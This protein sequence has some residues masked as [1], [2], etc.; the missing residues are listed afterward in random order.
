MN[1]LDY[2]RVGI[3]QVATSLAD[4]NANLEKHRQ[5]IDQ[6][7]AQH[8]DLLLFPELSLTGYNLK[9]QTLDVALPTSHEIFDELAAIATNM[10]VCVGFVEE[11]APGEFYNAHAILKHGQM[12][13][14]HRKIN[15]PNYGP[16]EEGKWF[17]KGQAIESSEPFPG[18]RT[19]SL[20]GSDLWNPA[21][22]H[23][24]ML[25]KPSLLLAPMNNA[26]T[27]LGDTLLPSQGWET[28]TNFLSMTYGVPVLMANSCS[29]E[30]ELRFNGH[31]RILN[32]YGECVAEADRQEQLLVT[33]LA[34][35]D[36][37]QARFQLPTIR[38]ANSALVN[39]LL[40]NRCDE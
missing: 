9:Q 35:R 23:I 3:G 28:N 8:I 13:H 1:N 20:I 7:N 15:L 22:P 26:E 4:L 30:G 33:E 11:A 31:S 17:S 40:R 5:F 24:A 14:L 19:H 2:L 27:L 36:I 32:A 21:L 10:A 6:A 12:I 29:N 39:K 25:D 18:W 16:F 37:R 34:L 38:D